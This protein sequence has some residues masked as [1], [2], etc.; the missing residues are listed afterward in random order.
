MRGMT[1]YKK[2][3]IYY[4]KASKRRSMITIIGVAITVIVLYA[5]LNLAYSFFLNGREE[6]RKEADYEIVFLTEDNEKLA[7]I[8][9][10]D[11][12]IRAY[13]GSYETMEP[14]DNGDWIDVFYKN[15]LY[16][17]TNHP[18]QMES[19]MEDMMAEY[20]VN[21]EINWELSDYYFQ[22]SDN[23]L[24][25]LV[26]F[27]LLIA[28]IFAI[29]A[30]GIIRNTIQ[31]FTL[32]QVK[33]Y[34]I[35]RCVGSTKKQLKAIIYIMGAVL[36]GTG[37]G[38]GVLIGVVVSVIIGFTK[39]INAG[40]HVLPMIPILIAYFGDLYFVMNENCKLVTK[41]TPI[42]AVRGE[43]RIK[44]EKFKRRGKG[45]MG[46]VF[47]I[48]GE[49]ARKS[50]LRNK[51]RFLKTVA[52]MIF[53]ITAV[54][55]GLSCLKMITGSIDNINDMYGDYP[56]AYTSM[57][58]IRTDIEEAVS[59]LPSAEEMVG[60]ADSKYIL[61]AKKVYACMT[62]LVDPV[63]FIGKMTED[64]KTQT[65]TGDMY[66]Y[67]MDYLDEDASK[68]RSD[69]REA[70]SSMAKTICS[71]ITV[72][73]SDEADLNYL[74]KYLKEGTT[75][76]SEN[77]ILV[78]VGGSVQDYNINSEIV[79]LYDMARHYD[80]YNFQL[81]ETMDIVNF[82]LYSKRCQEAFDEL[83]EE[84]DDG[85]EDD[86]SGSKMRE[87][88]KIQQRIKEELIKEGEYTT[89]VVE[90]ILD[91]GDELLPVQSIYM[92]RDA[93]FELT[94]F[95]EDQISGVQYK[96]DTDKAP[97]SFYQSLIMWDMSGYAESMIGLQ[98][99]KRVIR[100]VLAAVIFIFSLSSVNI[101]NTTAGSLHLRR[102]EFA[103]LRVIGMSRKRLI[104]TVMLEGVMTMLISNVIGF[105]LG[106]GL[107]FAAYSYIN[108][109]IPVKRTIAW[110]TFLAAFVV[111]GL[112]ICGSIYMTIRELP[113]AMVDD[114]KIE[115]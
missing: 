74:S 41:M 105:A 108:L 23:G 99:I 92:N 51:G 14:D 91:F 38:I 95:T 40:F 79:T 3:A 72:T 115:E 36:E 31:M 68:D 67:Y 42:S 53:S 93:Y 47:G 114:L 9:A 107:T 29:F 15:A 39:D 19:I 104:R 88:F 70:L 78:A 76:L 54:I 113:A 57:P 98:S 59:Y 25:V 24:M 26:I 80:A 83:E 50:V 111:S 18:Y 46:L 37:I 56:L 34:G 48:E 101:I 45:L 87:E 97:V 16:T 55:A 66:A 32:E 71:E 86:Y 2:L 44:K 11:R 94:G 96:I 81:G 90:G 30:V 43:Y 13:T 110:G 64:Y 77:G 100:Y 109:L 20:D 61:E 33:D 28:Y 49:Y 17:V 112:I 10:D 106:T 85:T 84:S 58:S 1:D 6:V 5:G 27:I 75:E 12:I 102:K 82:E 21:A 60:M 65:V 69:N 7:Q 73:G 22:D 52:A 4:L 63:E 89:Y 35:L 103:Q 8:A 62:E